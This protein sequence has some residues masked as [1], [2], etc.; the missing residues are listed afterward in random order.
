MGMHRNSRTTKLAAM[1]IGESLWL[2]VPD[3][4]RLSAHMN[5]IGVD[6]RRVEEHQADVKFTQ[7]KWIAMNPDTGD[8]IF[9]V[10]VTKL[11]RQ[12]IP[13]DNAT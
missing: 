5:N 9:L 10:R 12:E 4:T 11:N 13:N 8:T 2:P 3:A 1:S 6:M 7:K